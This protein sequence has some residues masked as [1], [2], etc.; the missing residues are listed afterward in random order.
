[1]PHIEIEN[2]VKEFMGTEVSSSGAFGAGG[3]WADAGATVA[4]QA[5][6]TT[7]TATTTTNTTNNNTNTTTNNNNLDDHLPCRPLSGC[8]QLQ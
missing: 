8:H 6:K 5:I 3:A 4:A 2:N 7:S 1:M